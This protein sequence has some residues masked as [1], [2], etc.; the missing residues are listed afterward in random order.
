MKVLQIA[1]YSDSVGGIAIQVRLLTEKLRSE[2]IECD[3]L[4]TKGSLFKRIKAVFQLL[5][6][7]HKYDVFHIHACSNRG[8]FPAMVGIPVGRLLHKRV[9]STYHGGGAE[10]FFKKRTKLI[11][12]FLT[13]TD[14]NIVLSGFIGRIYEEY[15][16]GY[17]IVP[18]IV[19]LDDCHFKERTHIKPKFISTRLLTEVY[20]LKCTIKAFRIVKEDYPEASLMILGDGPLK[21]DLEQFVINNGIKDVHFIGRVENNHI[22]DYLDQADVLVNSSRFDNMPVS[23]LEGFNAGTLVVSSG[24]GGIPYII[25]DGVNGLLYRDNDYKMMASKMLYSLQHE[26]HVLSM[27]NNARECIKALSWD[28]IKEKYFTV[29]NVLR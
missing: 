22:Y 1:N 12:H 20:N 17:V 4:S 25:A 26:E 15:G 24:V 16:L 19:E 6:L 29:Y 28:L 2:G 13:R 18:N 7:G 3:I 23:I 21:S 8:F 27:I 11:K 10:E 14:Q 5:T 9:V